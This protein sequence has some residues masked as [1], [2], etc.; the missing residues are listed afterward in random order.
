[1]L[2]TPIFING[3]LKGTICFETTKD[4]KI[5]DNEDINFARTISDIT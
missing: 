1:M 4:K 5:W 3:R 2:D